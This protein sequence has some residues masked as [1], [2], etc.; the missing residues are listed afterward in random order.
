VEPRLVLNGSSRGF[1]LMGTPWGATGKQGILLVGTVGV[2]PRV[3]GKSVAL[4]PR[5]DLTCHA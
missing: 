2:L 5:E 1:V 3:R 4:A